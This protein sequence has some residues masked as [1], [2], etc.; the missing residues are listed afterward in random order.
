MIPMESLWIEMIFYDNKSPL[1]AETTARQGTV[2]GVRND[3]PLL[4]LL[5]SKHSKNAF[6]KLD[7]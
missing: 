7:S 5:N 4:T 3:R 2:L 1:L 6:F